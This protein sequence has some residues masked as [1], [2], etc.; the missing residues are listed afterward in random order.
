MALLFQWSTIFSH[1]GLQTVAGLAEVFPQLAGPIPQQWTD[2]GRPDWREVSDFCLKYAPE[3]F[4][5]F[6]SGKYG[7]NLP[8][9]RILLRTA[10]WYN[11]NC[12]GRH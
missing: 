1:N 9:S 8:E 10:A 12:V 2:T 7:S 3:K 6:K 4:S 11:S 5:V